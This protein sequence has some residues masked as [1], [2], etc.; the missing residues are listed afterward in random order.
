MKRNQAAFSLI[1]VMVVLVIIGMLVAIIAPNVLERA[2]DARQQKVQADFRSIETAL[3]LYR[4]DNY[5]YPTSEQ[6]LQALVEQPSLDPLPRN[7]KN[8]GYL[9]QLPLDPWGRPYLYLRPAE[10]S[11]G[12]YDLYTF[13][14]DGVAGGS[15]HD[16]DVGNWLATVDS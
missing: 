16:A 6:G 4:L 13:G 11:G 8:N 2:D 12:D 14:A 15:G 7:Y 9:E 5:A 10:R 3:K 1:E